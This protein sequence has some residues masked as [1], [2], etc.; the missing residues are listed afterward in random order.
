LV[1][2]VGGSGSLIKNGGSSLILTSP[3]NSWSG[4]T[5]IAGGGLQTGDGIV[6]GSLPPQPITNNGTLSFSLGGGTFTFTNQISGSGGIFV[7]NFGTT[8]LTAAN[9]FSNQ[10]LIN[11]T[12]GAAL[13]INNGNALGD[14]SGLTHIVGNTFGNGRLELLGGITVADP[15]LVDCRQANSIDVPLIVNVS[16]TN[17]LTGPISGT[18]GGSDWN[19][20]SDNG[21]L[22][23][24]GNFINTA[25]S[26]TR[27]IKLMG[28]GLGE[29]SGIIS[30]NITNASITSIVKTNSGTW[31]LSGAN[32]YTGSTTVNGGVLLVNGS[33]AGGGATVNSGTLGGS[34][35]IN[36]NVAVNAAGTLSPGNSIGTMTIFG[37]LSLAGTNVMELNKSGVTLTSDKIQGVSHLSFGGVLQLQIT[38]D[39]LT[40]TDSFLLY[41]AG[42]RDGLFTSIIPT[43]PGTGLAWNTNTLAA[44][45]ILRIANG[46]STVRTNIT[47]ISSGGSLDLSWPQDHTGWRLQAQ[48][49]P[50]TVGLHSNWFDVPGSTTTNHMIIPISPTN[51]SVFFRIIY[52]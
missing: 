2:G 51:G 8:I 15:F 11:S 34:G 4:G 48:T 22:T 38:G 21:K 30:N 17:T 25:T 13:R 43:T 49:N 45:G 10:V 12:N 19:F 1:G 26:A 33:I 3:T 27:L 40:T 50:I 46:V 6:N 16:D 23:I 35:T 14:T 39:P 44:D 5:L 37:N 28:A 42:L 32:E 52:P 7:T 18:T 47:M 24:A 36:G 31:T 9:T 20:Q 29:W 41:S